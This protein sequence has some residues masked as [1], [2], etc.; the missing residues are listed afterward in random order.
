MLEEIKW[1]VWR[2]NSVGFQFGP[3]ELSKE[4]EVVE[5]FG[6]FEEAKMAWKFYCHLLINNYG[7]FNP[8][9]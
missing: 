4:Q 7:K 1:A 5:E 6:T 2:D 8:D 9:N 3:I